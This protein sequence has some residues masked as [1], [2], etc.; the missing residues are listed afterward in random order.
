MNV[1]L[2]RN[3]SHKKLIPII[4]IKGKL[5]HYLPTLEEFYYIDYY[6]IREWWEDES[7]TM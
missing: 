6:D 5:Y 1:R 7:L 4:N 2:N 3:S